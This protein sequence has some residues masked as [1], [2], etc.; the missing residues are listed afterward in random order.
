MRI[1]DELKGI[2]STDRASSTLVAL[3]PVGVKNTSELSSEASARAFSIVIGLPPRLFTRY[4]S[5]SRYRS[6][7]KNSSLE[8]I[9]IKIMAILLI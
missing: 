5:N 9:R 1:T 3:R 7:R 8:L 6:V 2:C 4:S